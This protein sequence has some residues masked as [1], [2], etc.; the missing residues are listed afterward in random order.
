MGTSTRPPP[1]LIIHGQQSDHDHHH[2]AGHHRGP[3]PPR[4]LLHGADDQAV[5]RA[6]A[7]QLVV[8]GGR[9]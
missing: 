3:P 4:W 5:C 1:A 7:M 2:H 6:W 9:I 8:E